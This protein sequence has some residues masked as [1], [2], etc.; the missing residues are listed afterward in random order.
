MK[1][2]YHGRVWGVWLIITAIKMQLHALIHRVKGLLP[3]F[4]HKDLN[5]KICKALL[6]G[7][8]IIRYCPATFTALV[9]FIEPF[10]KM[11]QYNI[12]Y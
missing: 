9:K 11:L 12:L 1:I 8:V 6:M 2:K 3:L 4:F 10:H 5:I 7:N